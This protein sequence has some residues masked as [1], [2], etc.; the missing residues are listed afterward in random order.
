MSEQV[1]LPE[2]TAGWDYSSL[3]SNILLGRD[4]YLERKESFGRFRSTRNPG[5]ILGDRARILTW[6]TFNVEPGGYVEVGADTLLVGPV[7]MCAESIRVGARCVLSYNVTV[8]DC[9]FH[10]LDM[11]KRRRDAIA[12]APW[13]EHSARPPLLTKPVI[14]GNDVSIGNGAI[15]LKGVRIG[16]GATIAPGSVVSRDV[17]PGVLAIGNPASFVEHTAQGL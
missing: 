13:G 12:N 14:I 15:I 9:D 6:T 16:D 10:P 2:F 3:P 1:D 7:F 17:P 8:A 4:C 11:E 5:L